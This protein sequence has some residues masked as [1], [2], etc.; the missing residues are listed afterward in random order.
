M[1]HILRID[2]R[3]H[4]DL[5]VPRNSS[6][7]FSSF[8]TAVEAQAETS[9]N[10]ALPPTRC[11]WLPIQ[12]SAICCVLNQI[13]TRATPVAITYVHSGLVAAVISA[14]TLALAGRGRASVPLEA[15]RHGQLDDC[16]A[17]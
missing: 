4:C 8:S 5:P 16:H 7:E 3:T 10:N 12:A 13:C 17:E 9:T 1:N 6:S 11:R 15:N 2:D 14:C